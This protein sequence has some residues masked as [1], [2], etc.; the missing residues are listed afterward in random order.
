MTNYNEGQEAVDRFTTAMLAI[1]SVPS[2][3]APPRSAPKSNSGSWSAQLPSRFVVRHATSIL[4]P[5]FDLLPFK[6]SH[7]ARP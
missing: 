6:T 2:D 3:R 7:P 4:L 1:V 5:M